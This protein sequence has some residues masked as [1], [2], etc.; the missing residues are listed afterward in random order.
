[1]GIEVWN[2]LHKPVDS[3]LEDDDSRKYRQIL[4]E[5]GQYE[6]FRKIMKEV[7][8]VDRRMVHQANFLVVYLDLTVFPFGT[9]DE[10]VIA[11][12]EKKPSIIICKQGK[13]NAPDYCFGMLP[14]EMI[15][16]NFDQAIKYLTKVDQDEIIETYGR[17][18][19]FK[20]KLRQI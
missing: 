6:E 15:F 19:F 11:C 10:L 20:K 17:W 18:I 2:P 1:M 12:L 4:K 14:H 3:G 13:K 16:D 5:S 8:R 7:V 9:I